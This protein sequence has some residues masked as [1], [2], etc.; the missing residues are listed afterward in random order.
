MNLRANL[1]TVAECWCQASGRTFAQAGYQIF[2]DQRRLDAVAAGNNDLR[3]SSF[4]KAMRWFSDN[5][6]D[7]TEWPSAIERPAQVITI[8]AAQ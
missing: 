6:P 1:I 7:D 5:W 8:E 2:K 3:L 4:E